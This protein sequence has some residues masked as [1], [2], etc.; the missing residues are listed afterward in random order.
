MMAESKQKRAL[1]SRWA[2]YV[3]QSIRKQI[4]SL[5]TVLLLDRCSGVILS[6]FLARLYKAF[7]RPVPGKL[8]MKLADHKDTLHRKSSELKLSLACIG[9]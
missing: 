7:I 9:C 8:R 3:D 5:I 4:S 1:T 6:K 2:M